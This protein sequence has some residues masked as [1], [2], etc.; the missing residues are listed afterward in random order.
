MKHFTIL[1]ISTFL[2]SGCA[3][4]TPTESIIDNHIE[5]INQVLDYSYNNIEQTQDVIFLEKE[6]EVCQIGMRNTKSAYQAEISTCKAEK[7]QWQIYAF[8][9]VLLICAWFFVKIKRIF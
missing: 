6:L 7:K 3:K 9:L 4:Q 1:L 8:G 2:L 5:H